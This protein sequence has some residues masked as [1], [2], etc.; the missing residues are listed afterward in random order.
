MAT[1][2]T[3]AERFAEVSGYHPATLDRM[4]RD[5]RA[6]GLIPMGEKGR[7]TLRGHYEASHLANLIVAFWSDQPSDAAET[8]ERVRSMSFQ[9]TTTR[10]PGD[11]LWPPSEP[12]APHIPGTNPVDAIAHMIEG[13]AQRQERMEAAGIT[14]D[15][16]RALPWN[17]NAPGIRVP[18]CITFYRRPSSVKLEWISR[19]TGKISRI[20]TYFSRNT[21]RCFVFNRWYTIESRLLIPFAAE[22]LRT[23]P[24]RK[25][26][27][28]PSSPAPAV[29]NAGQ[30][31]ESAGSVPTPPAPT[32]DRKSARSASRTVA[33]LEHMEEREKSQPSRGREPVNSPSRRE[34]PRRDPP[35]DFAH[36]SAA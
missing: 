11:P 27:L 16:A 32:R 8:V 30:E 18:D 12:D 1:S 31:N 6:A 35:E 7:G 21:E 24:M 2:R 34:G 20:D 10:A 13:V 22:V 9:M 29:P 33:S 5:L 25:R 19:E 17:P 4:Q 26:A 36:I 14:E 23:N 3:V 28:P 15:D